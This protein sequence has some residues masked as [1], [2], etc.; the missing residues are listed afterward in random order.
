MAASFMTVSAALLA[1]GCG[2]SDNGGSPACDALTNYTPTATAVSFATDV[3]P[4]ISRT[5]AATG[6]CSEA[7]ACHGNP[8]IGLTPSG[9]RPMQYLFDPPSPAMAKSSLMGESVNAPSMRNVVAGNVG[10]SFL[11]YKIS[12]QEALACVSTKCVAGSTNG[13]PPCG[14]P[15][16]TIGSI[17]A[18]DR[19][20]I[21]DWIATG[22]AD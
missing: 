2:G 4:I 22:A 20:K 7:V 11:A 12:G 19:T 18:A 5:T 17:S 15:M 6:G 16:P 14:A 9:A 1:A 10:Q 3:Y 21:L 8:P 13:P